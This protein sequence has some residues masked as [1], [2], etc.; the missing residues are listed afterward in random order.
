MWDMTHSHGRVAILLYCMRDM[1]HL[2]LSGLIFKAVSTSRCTAHTSVCGTC[3]TRSWL[4]RVCD[5]THSDSF[6]RPCRHFAVLSAR[7]CVWRNWFICVT[8]L[9]QKFD[10][11]YSYVRVDISLYCTHI[12]VCDMTPACVWHD[13]LIE[14]LKKKY[15]PCRYLAVLSL[16]LCVWCDSCIC[17]SRLFHKR[18]VTRLNMGHDSFKWWKWLIH[19][20][21][22]T[23]LHAWRESI[24][25]GTLFVY[26]EHDLFIWRTWLIYA[27]VTTRSCVCHDSFIHVPWLDQIWDM[28]PLN[29]GHDSFI[30]MSQ[31]LHARDGTRSNMGHYLF[32]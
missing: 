5:V 4:V 31:L 14:G 28:T 19:M 32:I 24:K 21:V 20:H 27:R 11:T 29:G 12:Y 8:W 25:Y 7:L 30:C 10:V 9:I 6:V 18:A 22:T 3:A 13:S 2:Y 1:T 23:C 17:L 15:R 26:L 16:R